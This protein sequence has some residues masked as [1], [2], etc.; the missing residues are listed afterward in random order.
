MVSHIG[1]VYVFIAVITWGMSSIGYKLA[2][3]TKGTVE[4]DPI[5]SLAFRYFIVSL[6]LTPIMI[7]FV[8]IQAL[9]ALN[10]EIRMNYGIFATLSALFD[11]FAHAAYFMALRHLDSSRVYPFITFQ[12][13]LT[14]PFA[15]L[16][17]NE[18]IPRFLWLSALLI[19]LGVVSVSKP[20]HKD[21][22]FEN[23]T[24]EQKKSHFRKGIM[25]GLLTG[26]FFALFYLSMA[27][28]NRIVDLGE[29]ENNYARLI[30]SC[31]I[32]WTYL[33]IKRKHIPK[34]SHPEYKAQL[35]S[36]ITVGLFACLSAGIGDAVYQMGI[37]EN[38]AAISITI[39]SIAPLLN[40]LFAILFLKEKF[41]PRF[42]VGV[43]LIV[44]ANILVV[45]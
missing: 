44:I 16:V 6:V 28:Q 17:F 18:S 14:Y 40:Q 19:I 23:I 37:A 11:I 45:L 10:Q 35:K 25:Y 22:G 8:D 5:T 34:K 33:F 2:L 1:L 42:L 38:G 4:R 3:G 41:R 7:F 13:L 29:W 27:M 12:M 24:D 20:D 31:I 32:L 39:A 26:T 21:K 43:I 9:F 15:I 30:I 36:Y